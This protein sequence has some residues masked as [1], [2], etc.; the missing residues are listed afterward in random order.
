MVDETNAAT[1]AVLPIEIQSSGVLGRTC[2]L[3]P[4]STISK[5]GHG[6]PVSKN[7]VF[8]TDD[9]GPKTGRFPI[10]SVL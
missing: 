4:A 2:R 3:N 1:D 7:P 9:N 6:R 5:K 8:S 10:R